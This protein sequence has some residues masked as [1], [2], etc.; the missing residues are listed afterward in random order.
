[1][2]DKL[3][4]RLQDVPKSTTHSETEKELVKR[5]ETAN[6]KIK[7]L[8]VDKE[9]VKKRL[10]KL[11]QGRGKLEKILE[12]TRAREKESQLKGQEAQGQRSAELT[13]SY[14]HEIDRHQKEINEAVK[15][16]KRLD[17]E[18]KTWDLELKDLRDFEKMRRNSV[19]K[20]QKK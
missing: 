11:Y 8:E 14:E 9:F 7:K 5:A 16:L 2:L 10:D 12:R 6:F 20:V 1:M 3:L 17:G 15:I 13:R 18:Q 19:P 4:D